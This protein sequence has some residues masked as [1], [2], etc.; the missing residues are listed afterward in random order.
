MEDLAHDLEQVANSHVPVDTLFWVSGTALALAWIAV[1]L[2]VYVRAVL[3][4]AFGWDDWLMLITL[5]ILAS[6]RILVCTY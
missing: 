3:I 2:R 6:L 5:V 1:S 4:R